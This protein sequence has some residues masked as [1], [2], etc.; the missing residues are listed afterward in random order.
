MAPKIEH[1]DLLAQHIEKHI[2][3][4]ENIATL[5][6]CMTRI[7][8]VPKDTSKVDMDA[9]KKFDGVKGAI[10]S[11]DQYQVIVGMGTAAK[12][13]SRLNKRF[14]GDNGTSDT[15]TETPKPFSIRRML[16]TLSAIFVPT[17]PALIGCGL[18]LGLVNV[19]R[20]V[21]P[22]WVEQFPELFKLL[23]L[24]GSA[25]FAYLSIM[26]GMNTAKELGASTSIGAVMAGILALPGLAEI[27]LFGEKLVPNSGGIFAVL[28]VVVFSSKFEVWFRSKIWESLDLIVTPFITILVSA[29]VA[30]TI[31]QPIGH[32]LN[33]W[34]GAG[35]SFALLS[36]DGSA[37]ALGGLLGG[38]FLFLLL[39][40]LHQ[41]LIPIHAE[42]L[43]TFGL[44]YLFPILA[45]GG[46][47]QVGSC[48]WV[49]L[50]TKNKRLKKTLMGALPV[51]IFGVGEPLLFGVSLP[52]GKP[53]IAG[54]IGGA[55]GG[56]TI[57]F[58][59]VG[60]IIPFGTAGLSLIPLV[61]D[62]QI[63]PFLIS[64]LV[65]WAAGFIASMCLGF[66]DPT[67]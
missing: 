19:V 29:F 41:G 36:N 27:T 45:M 24:I 60:I 39:T 61:G 18:I 58:F 56:A 50:R 64:V 8:I 23:K 11:G 35:V 51:G 67:E 38:S 54:C 4:L 2:G 63:L 65:A 9:M 15:V 44:N 48:L 5:A 28:M 31:F 26:I 30:L 52:L 21:A 1:L 46:M 3:G 16:T 33:Q 47:G 17:I 7:R 12:V 13:F 22:G 34:L 53:F 55:F 66:T 49:F 6:H 37:V 59:K 43:Q 10:I 14:Q 32:F 40:G 20:L 57:A 25:V 62:G 42:I